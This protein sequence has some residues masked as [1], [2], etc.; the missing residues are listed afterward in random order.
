MSC[1]DA[2]AEQILLREHARARRTGMRDEQVA[3]RAPRP[4]APREVEK[5]GRALGDMGRDR[6]AE[7]SARA[8]EIERDRV[9]RVR[10]DPGP[11]PIR[12]ESVDA[13]LDLGEVLEANTCLRT[14]DLEIDGRPQTEVSAGDRG[15]AAVTAVA[16]R[17]HARS[18]A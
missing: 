2:V 1:D 4:L 3:V 15:G 5:L 7:L 17:A 16:D 18:K 14:E 10:R 13:L 9:R 8:I 6:K 11:D 12:E